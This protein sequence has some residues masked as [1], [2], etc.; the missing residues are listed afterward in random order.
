[1]RVEE[2]IKE[3]RETWGHT[4]EEVDHITFLV[5]EYGSDQYMRGYTDGQI[6]YME[7][8]TAYGKKEDWEE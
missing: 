7:V 1:M 3:L 5:T 2:I 6:D 4:G 8:F